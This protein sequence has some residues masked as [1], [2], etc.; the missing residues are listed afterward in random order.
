MLNPPRPNGTPRNAGSLSR[1]AVFVASLAVWCLL[2]PAAAQAQP[3]SELWDYWTAHDAASTV[4]IDHGAWNLFLGK[5]VFPRDDGINRL[6]YGNVL[7]YD[8]SALDQYIASLAAV[9]VTR[10][11]RHE[12]MAYWFNLYNALTVQLIL[13]A[14]PVSSIRDIDISPGFFSDGPWGKKLVEVEGKPVSLDDIE[15]RI[16]RPIWNDPR[17]HYAVSCAALGCPNIGTG[18]FTADKLDEYLDFSARAYINNPRAVRVRTG[19]LVLSSLYR[20]Y[21]DDFGGSVEAVIRHLAAYADPALAATLD[22]VTTI[23]GYEYDWGLND[24]APSIKDRLTK[25]GS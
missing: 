17:I 11:N 23:D 25:R 24:V 22:A 8:R 10:L 21:T 18:A 3:E 6:A 16:L 20:W 4:S 14:Y 2:A 7:F 1:A 19:E 12:Q 9:T 15:H 5:Y 13:G